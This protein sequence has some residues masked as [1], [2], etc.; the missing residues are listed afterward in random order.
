MKTGERKGEGSGA[1]IEGVEGNVR[2]KSENS[3]RGGGRLEERQA[4]GRL[5]M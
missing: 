5:F 4:S 2:V 3:S 1:A